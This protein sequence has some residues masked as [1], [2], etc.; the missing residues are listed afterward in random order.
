MA[1]CSA[2]TWRDC[3]ARRPPRREQPWNGLGWLRPRASASVGSERWWWAPC[4]GIPSQPIPTS[5]ERR[6]SRQHAGYRL[7]AVATIHPEIG[8][9]G[10]E[11]GVRKNLRHADEAGVGIAHG[12]ICVLLHERDNSLLMLA[13]AK[14][15]QQLV[16]F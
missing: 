2:P 16:T 11:D 4:G 12:Q 7:P 6:R 15:H 3:R 1:N 13:E 14:R 5:V 10:E 8:V 9:R